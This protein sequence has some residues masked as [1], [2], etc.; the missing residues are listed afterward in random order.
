MTALPLA[1]SLPHQPPPPGPLPLPL[2]WLPQVLLDG[3]EARALP[4]V[5][6]PEAFDR[7]RELTLLTAAAAAA[8]NISHLRCVPVA[9][10]RG[11][12]PLTVVGREEPLP[13]PERKAG[14]VAMYYLRA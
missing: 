10:V 12:F 5:P 1:R 11:T 2:P 6:L 7:A 13:P 3:N 8:N 4:G 9:N 14:P